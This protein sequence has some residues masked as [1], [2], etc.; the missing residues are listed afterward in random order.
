MLSESAKAKLISKVTVSKDITNNKT[1]DNLYKLPPLECDSTL[2]TEDEFS[3]SESTDSSPTKYWDLH[4]IDEKSSYFKSLPVD[5]KH[6]ILTEL[7]E[8][9]KQSSWGKIHE[10]PKQSDDFAT[11][12]MKRL[13]K[14]YSVQASLEEVEKEM[15]G[16]SLSLAELEQLLNDQGVVTAS[17]S[18]GNRIASDENT[19]YFLIKDIKKAMH[20]ATIQKEKPMLTKIIETDENKEMVEEHTENVPVDSDTEKTLADKE[21]ESDLQK[22]IQL[23]LQEVPSTSGNDLG[24]TR[25]Q[26]PS[27]SFLGDITFHSESESE[28]D[29]NTHL[30]TNQVLMSAKNYMVEYS[31]LTPSEIDKIMGQNDSKK[32]NSK[33]DKNGPKNNTKI[34]SCTKEIVSVSN[35]E[36]TIDTN[37]KKE[38]EK[39]INES[40]NI[41]T[42]TLSE[43][44]EDKADAIELMS[45]SNSD[46]DDLLEVSDKIT[47]DAN[48][49]LAKFEI[50]IKPEDKLEDDI[51]SD[52]FSTIEKKEHT[53]NTN[54]NDNNNK[55]EKTQEQSN[56]PETT[57]SNREEVQVMETYTKRTQENLNNTEQSIKAKETTNE[58]PE[59]VSSTSSQGFIVEQN[60]VPKFT[61]TQLEEMEKQLFMEKE[62][63]MT[64]KFTKERMATNL[65]DEIYQE[66][67]VTNILNTFLLKIMSKSYLQTNMKQILVFRNYY[68]Y[69]EC[70]I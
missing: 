58:L 54:I 66:A 55:I 70:L 56:I 44:D 52:I 39:K 7:K 30:N 2:S 3:T 1:D 10:L 60:Q 57:I 37:S 21:Y 5:V 62:E 13:L 14:R 64:E 33:I 27:Y 53:S 51:F 9:R 15:G 48:T 65:T 6:D 17:D 22:A 4:T 28:D 47:I 23:S 32:T 35:K 11:F 12:Q 41:V 29:S 63:L 38:P 40:Q 31:G 67:Q 45:D 43:P 49:K 8:T 16:R 34:S 36:S 69:L 50:L 42:T 24:Y 59:S 20:E 18:L 46:V 68:N 26:N 61:T 25:T 19:K